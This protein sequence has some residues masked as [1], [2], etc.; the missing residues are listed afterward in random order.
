[1]DNYTTHTFAGMFLSK[2]FFGG[3][4][5]VRE[6]NRNSCIIQSVFIPLAALPL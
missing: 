6:G 1:M 3:A 5:S 4:D 2:S